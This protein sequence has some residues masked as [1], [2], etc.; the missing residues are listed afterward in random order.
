[1]RG[2]IR[3]GY[4]LWCWDGSFGVFLSGVLGGCAGLVAQL[5]G[6]RIYKGG[7]RSRVA[8]CSGSSFVQGVSRLLDCRAMRIVGGWGSCVGGHT[9]APLCGY[10]A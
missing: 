2:Q 9:A 6:Y 7:S 10:A 1:M 8:T 4:F 5:R 3:H